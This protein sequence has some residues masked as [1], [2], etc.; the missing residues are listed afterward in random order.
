MQQTNCKNLN[1]K[2][3]KKLLKNKESMISILFLVGDIWFMI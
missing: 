1:K 3:Y 2:I